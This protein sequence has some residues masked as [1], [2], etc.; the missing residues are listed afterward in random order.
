MAKAIGRGY[1]P[2]NVVHALIE[3]SLERP[4]RT[5]YLAGTACLT[6]EG[7][8][9]TFELSGV[10]QLC[11]SKGTEALRMPM[12]AIVATYRLYRTC[13]G[14]TEFYVESLARLSELGQASLKIK[15]DSNG[16]HEE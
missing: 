15:E 13:K 6:L 4:K 14:E 2:A 12:R 9:Y 10:A 16:K 8:T 11:T 5:T 1:L 3:H 7:E